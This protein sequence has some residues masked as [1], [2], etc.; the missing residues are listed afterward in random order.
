MYAYTFNADS[1]NEIKPNS[2]YPTLIS[3]SKAVPMHAI[4]ANMGVEV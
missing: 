4:Q 2:A 3:K 1:T